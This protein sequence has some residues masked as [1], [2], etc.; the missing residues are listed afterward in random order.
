MGCAKTIRIRG[1]ISEFDMLTSVPTYLKTKHSMTVYWPYRKAPIDFSSTY[2]MRSRGLHYSK[3]FD[4][5]ISTAK[6]TCKN[7][8]TAVPRN[9][10]NALVPAY[11]LK[12]PKDTTGRIEARTNQSR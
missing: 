11:H 3:T 9:I 6:S 10:S 1:Q 4:L 12:T 8:V 5:F 7:P 2:S